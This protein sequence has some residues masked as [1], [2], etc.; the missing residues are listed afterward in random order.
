MLKWEARAEE[1]DS[2]KWLIL[3]AYVIGLSIG[4]LAQPAHAAG[5]G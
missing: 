3:I 5:L 2:D 1:A 4:A